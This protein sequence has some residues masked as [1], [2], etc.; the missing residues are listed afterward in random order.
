M[1]DD[2]QDTR[3]LAQ[4][5]ATSRAIARLLFVHLGG[6]DA[7]GLDADTHRHLCSALTAAERAVTIQESRL[8]RRR[9]A[10][11]T[12]EAEAL[13]RPPQAG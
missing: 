1:D 13:G 7:D 10:R 12:A 5:H 3:R 11:W 9:I 2:P 6:A 8:R 4:L